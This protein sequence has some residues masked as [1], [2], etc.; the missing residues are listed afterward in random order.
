MAGARPNIILFV[1][2]DHR[3][4][5]LRHLGGTRVRTPMLD[6]LAAAG[7]SFARAHSQGSMHPAVCVPSRA[8]L[9]TGRSIFASSADPTGLDFTAAQT[10]PA[11]LETFPQALRAGGYHTHAVGKWHNDRVSFNRSFG[12]GR[13]IF[14]GGMSDHYH[15][16][17]H[18]YDPTG[19]Y[20]ETAVRYEER[21]ST[22][23]F[24]DAAI[25]FLEDRRTSEPFFLYVAYTAPHDPRTPPPRWSPKAS[26]IEIAPNV[27]PIH[28]FDNGEMKVRDELISVA[29]RSI[30]EVRNQLSAYYGMIA[31]LDHAV[32][33]VMR[34]LQARGMDEHTV[35]IYTSDHGLAVGQHGLMGKQNLYQP[36]LR[37]PLVMAGPGVPQGEI[38]SSL[39][40]HADTC[41]TIRAMA[42]LGPDPNREGVDVLADPGRIG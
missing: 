4:T 3:G 6:T 21:F 40:W 2:D 16:P 32:G 13:A 8:S 5:A 12:S 18:D 35:V 9:L 37:I 1:A 42:G 11:Q 23:I 41:A 33:R 39:A 27:V 30:S 19:A 25:D 28:P 38:D 15:V 7:V 34:I 17:L 26:Q 29:P 10:I 14:F 36:S 24:T 20:P 31:H 22:D